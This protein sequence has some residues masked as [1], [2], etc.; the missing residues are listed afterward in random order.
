MGRTELP[1]LWRGRHVRPYAFAVSLTMVVLA[2]YL[3]VRGYDPGASLSG[4][5]SS[6]RI[7]GG[8]A[9]LSFALL[10]G[11][12]WA[13]RS[14][15]MKLGLLGTAGVMATRTVMIF[16]SVGFANQSAWFS[17]C[18]V[19]ASSGAYLLELTTA[20]NADGITPRHRAM[21]SA[22][23]RTERGRRE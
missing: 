19:L 3:L 2:W 23:T 6:G 13:Q 15:L 17:A 20:E 14:G 11:G 1:W 22:R 9:F 16:Y 18:W 12:F 10:W 5:S 7:V 4:H 21:L 8:A